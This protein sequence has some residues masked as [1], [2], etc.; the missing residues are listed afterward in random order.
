MSLRILIIG[1]GNTLRRDDGVGWRVARHVARWQRPGVTAQAL[2]QLTPEL[3]AD[4]SDASH[5]LFV[6]AAQAQKG[7]A[8]CMVQ[9]VAEPGSLAHAGDPGRLLGWTQ[10]LY[11]RQPDSWLLTIPACDTGLGKQIS[12]LGRQGMR[13]AL[14]WIRDW[15][16]ERFE[17][18]GDA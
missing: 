14:A 3:A 11:G 16:D 17:E 4:L 13:A 1:Y 7:M 8:V 9:P 12:P 15:L 10:A 6:D 5:A 2:F 18:G